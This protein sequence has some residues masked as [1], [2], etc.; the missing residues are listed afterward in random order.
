MD[1]AQKK[2]CKSPAPAQLHILISYFLHP[3]SYFSLPAHF[4][5]YLVAQKAC[6]LVVGNGRRVALYNTAV[7]LCVL[8]GQ[9]EG[10]YIIVTCLCAV[11]RHRF[12][13]RRDKQCAHSSESAY[14]LCVGIFGAYRLEKPDILRCVLLVSALLIHSVRRIVGAKIDN[15]HIGLEA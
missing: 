2:L 12:V 5:L 1:N 10:G 14:Y 9:V 4:G 8:Q 3:T 13:H 15:D 6:C 7:L 11:L